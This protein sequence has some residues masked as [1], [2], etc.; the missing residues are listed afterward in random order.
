LRTQQAPIGSDVSRRRRFRAACRT[1]ANLALAVCLLASLWLIVLL[2]AGGFDARVFGLRLR[3]NDPLHP[4]LI[5]GAALGVFSILRRWASSQSIGTWSSGLRDALPLA[6]ILAGAAVARFWALGFG[7]PSLVCRPDEDAIASIAGGYYGG[8]LHTHSFTYPPL[9]MLVVAAA[10]HVVEASPRVLRLFTA[11]DVTATSYAARFLIARVLS[12]MAGIGTVAAVYYTGARIAGRRVGL[13]AAACLAL[14][15]LHVRDSHFGVTDVPMTFLLAVAFLWTA[16]LSASGSR[17]D[18][19]GAAIFAGLATA[20]KYNAALMVLPATFVLLTDPADRPIG[21]RFRRVALFFGLMLVT[22]LVVAP[23]SLVEHRE[24]VAELRLVAANLA[25]DGRASN[26]GRGWTYHFTTTLRYGLGLPL[27]VAGLAGAVML[28]RRQPR[29]GICVALFPLAYYA[30]AGNGYTVFTRHMEPV[31]PFICLTAGY[32]IATASEWMAAALRRPSWTSGLAAIGA[33]LVLWPS[34]N[35]VIA[36]DRLLARDDSR[37]LARRWIDERV[38]AGSTIAQLGPDTGRAVTG[39]DIEP[40]YVLV[41][42]TPSGPR[43]DVVIVQFSP[44]HHSVGAGGAEPILAADYDLRT[45]INAAAPDAANVYDRQDHFYLPMSG[46]RQVERPGPNLRIYVR[47]G[48][49]VR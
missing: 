31:V 24:M 8:Y 43:P 33:G 4:A 45:S 5:A 7:L 22:F 36:F 10:M 26:L 42:L 1:G 44:L 18:L 46:F 11:H 6:L 3:S 39:G 28:V 35:A 32:A 9:F 2:V 21:E 14:A 17:S 37:L 30:V 34:A 47:R 48:V 12:A 41:D 38:P 19:I 27:L 25:G 29:V 40:P 20:T 49:V 15:F 16:K 13:A 23:F